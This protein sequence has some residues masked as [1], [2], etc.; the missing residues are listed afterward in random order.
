[1]NDLIKLVA[2]KANI[3]EATA[4]VAVE[5]VVKFLKEKLPDPLA[6]QLDSILSGKINPNQLGDLAKGLGG[7][8]GKK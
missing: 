5:T 4:K 1:M 6:D 7:L 8:L 2:E 3:P